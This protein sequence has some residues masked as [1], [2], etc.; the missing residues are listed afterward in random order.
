MPGRRFRSI[1]VSRHALGMEGDEIQRRPI[2]SAGGVAAAENV[3]KE[4]AQILSTR[5]SCDL[6]TAYASSR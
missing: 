6:S 5:T 4:E 1:D 3:V 2:A